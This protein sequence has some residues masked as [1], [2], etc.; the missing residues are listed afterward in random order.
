MQLLIKS[1][2]EEGEIEFYRN[3]EGKLLVSILNGHG[4]T[5]YLMDKIEIKCLVDYIKLT[6]KLES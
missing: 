4:T 2:N 5:Y 6:E 3:N 1:E